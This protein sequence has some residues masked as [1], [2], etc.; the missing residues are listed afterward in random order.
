[1]HSFII[2]LILLLSN[3]TFAA[4][5]PFTPHDDDRFTAVEA[6]A[7][8]VETRA[9]SLETRATSLESADTS[10]D[11]RID[12][13]E[14]NTRKIASGIFTVTTPKAAASTFTF[15]ANADIPAG[16]IILYAFMRFNSAIV[17]ADQNTVAIACGAITILNALDLT[18]YATGDFLNDPFATWPQKTAAGCTPTATVG[19]GASGITAGSLEIYVEYIDAQ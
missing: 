14:L 12:A 17:S 3:L 16:S 15:G 8:A 9:S 13:L 5:I 4:T 1:M 2:G 19:A 10:L 7:S 18:S 6:R 11:T